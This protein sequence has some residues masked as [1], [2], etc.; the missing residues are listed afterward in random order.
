MSP[1]RAVHRFGH[2]HRETA[3]T[4]IEPRRRIRLQQQVHMINLD[5]ELK[6]PEPAAGRSHARGANVITRPLLREPTLAHA[7]SVTWAGHRGS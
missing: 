7:R 5:A 1:E 2:P 3:H 4:T 6:N